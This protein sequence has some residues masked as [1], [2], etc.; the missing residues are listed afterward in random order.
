MPQSPYIIATKSPAPEVFLYDYKK[1][2]RK[3]AHER[4]MCWR[5]GAADDPNYLKPDWLL[6]GHE[7]QGWVTVA[8]SL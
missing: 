4:V 1:H 5:D 8:Y 2:P 6:T 3:G 7:D